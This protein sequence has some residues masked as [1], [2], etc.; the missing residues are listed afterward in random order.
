[1]GFPQVSFGGLFSTI[2]DPT[3]FVSREN[4]SFEVYD[5][6]LIDRGAHHVKFGGYLFHLRFNPVNPQ[7]ARGAFTF[8]GQ[9]SGNAFADFLLGY[10]SAAQVGIGR[11]DEHGRT[12]WFHAYGQD[13]WQSH[14]EPHDQLRASLRDQ[15]PDGRCRQPVVG[16]RP[17]GARRPLRHR[18]RRPRAASRRRRSRCCPQIPIAL[19][20]LEGCRLDAGSAATR[21]ISGSRRGW[22]WPGRLA[23]THET[24]VTA[25][26][27]VFLN[28]WAYSVQQSLA[29]TL[30]FFFAEDR[31]C[32]GRR[33]PADIPDAGRCCS[34]P[35]TARS[36]ATR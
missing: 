33:R 27:G 34:R 16:H 12:T 28:Q 36:A 35:P 18:E 30:P 21:A 9:W 3:S 25:G 8:N 23:R 5:N 1:M 26:F 15:Q 22:V 6:V 29:Q 4:R 10:P 7:A 17:L 11:A 19:R 2:G 20:H 24:V 31:Q 32:R 13:D 14:A